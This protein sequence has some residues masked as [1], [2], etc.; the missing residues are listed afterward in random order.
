MKTKTISDQIIAIIRK[1][2]YFS[3]ERVERLMIQEGSSINSLGRLN[4]DTLKKNLSRMQL[5]KIIFDAGRGWYSTVARGF[6]LET[7]AVD[8]LIREIK[9]RFPLM[10]F[11]CWSTKQL[12]SFA[13]H[14]M[15]KF[16]A[17]VYADVDFLPSINEH[18]D[19]KD[20]NVY[21]N[22][23]KPEMRKYYSLKERTCILRPGISEEPVEGHYASIEKILVDL[24]IEKDRINL[25][26]GS[27]Y[28][29]IFGNL[30]TAYRINIGRMLRYANRR[31]VKESLMKN[32]FREEI[33]L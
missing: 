7:E 31:E 26:D 30:V 18:L 8:E 22:P 20:Y 15:T 11:S 27:E 13:H 33:F 1:K 4:R 19:E 25:M 14:M 16:V 21:R 17:F 6:E 23:T 10:E 9:S 32:V 29:R 24:Y 3:F 2:N 28:K 5:R 12:Q